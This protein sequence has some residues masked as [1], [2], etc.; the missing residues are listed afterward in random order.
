M[1]YQ[2][3]IMMPQ[4]I[5]M[6]CCSWEYFKTTSIILPV[7]ECPPTDNLQTHTHTPLPLLKISIHPSPSLCSFPFATIY[8]QIQAINLA[9]YTC[10]Y[11]RIEY[12][13]TSACCPLLLY[14]CIILIIISSPLIGSCFTSIFAKNSSSAD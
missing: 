3:V 11:N 7:F 5:P 9:S 13:N 6:L 1:A 14:N 8:G 2:V 10:P 12:S 4:L